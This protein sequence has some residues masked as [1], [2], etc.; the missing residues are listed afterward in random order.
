L[1]EMVIKHTNV[2]GVRIQA[3]EGDVKLDVSVV[4]DYGV[5]IP[6]I[7]DEVQENVKRS[8]EKMTGLVLS[9]VNVIVE[10]VAIKPRVA[11]KKT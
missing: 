7:A 2:K 9:E 5:D 10:S 1:Y 4:V 8:I 3:N 6:R 11:E